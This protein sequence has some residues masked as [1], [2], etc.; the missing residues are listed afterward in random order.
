MQSEERGA[1]N[2]G[3]FADE[4][5]E[6]VFE[7]L[8]ARLLAQ[9]FQRSYRGDFSGVHNGYSVAERFHFRHDVRGKNNRLSGVPAAANEAR[10]SAGGNNVQAVGGFVE[11]KHGRAVQ[12]S[13]GDGNALLLSGGEFVATGI[14]ER[15]NVQFRENF[16][17]AR[18]DF[19]AGQT[20]EFAE[21]GHHFPRRHAFVERGRARQK[22][23][24]AADVL[25]LPGNIKALNPRRA[26]SGL[27]NRGEHPQRRRFARAI[28]PQQ[29]EYL[30]GVTLKRN[31]IH[32]VDFASFFILK[33][34]AKVVDFNHFYFGFRIFGFLDCGTV[35][36]YPHYPTRKFCQS[37]K[38]RL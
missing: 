24:I 28:R 8:L 30:A 31:A 32:R 2:L 38:S 22:A 18:L 34:F 13:A 3:F 26:G 7:G 33:S 17:D 21:I 1:G 14:G 25:A 29:P 23:D 15:E 12:N 16:F 9:F 37:Y 27:Q 11:E 10:D 35:L 5:Q 19:R 6:N 4:A 20:V 36:L